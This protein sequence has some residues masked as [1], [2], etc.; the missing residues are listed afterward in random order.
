MLWNILKDWAVL[1]RAR[2]ARFYDAAVEEMSTGARRPGLWAKALV[3][4]DGEERAVNANYIR[5]LVV[6]LK[7]E[8]YVAARLH[9]QYSHPQPQSSV[10]MF[11][12]IFTPEQMELMRSLAVVHNGKYFACGEMHFD[13]F[14]DAIAFAR[15]QRR[16]SET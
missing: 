7:D 1:G 16:T 15:N 8:A 12:S 2:D 11:P 13:H 6:A 14:N 10:A 5:L 3:K 4:A 9:S